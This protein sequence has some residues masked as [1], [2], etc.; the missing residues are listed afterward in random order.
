[1][2][3]PAT[4]AIWAGPSRTRSAVPLLPL[5][6]L[7]LVQGITEFLPISSSGHLILVWEGLDAGGL[8]TP[9]EAGGDRLALDVAVHVGT[10]AAVCGY[11]RRDLAA[12]I[13]G[14]LRWL[15]GGRDA[16]ARLAINVAVATLP[17][18]AVGLSAREMVAEHLRSVELVA[19][20]TLIFGVALYAA[21]RAGGL[22]RKLAEMDV[23]DALIV[24]ML[25][26]LALMPGTS[27]AGITAT[28]GRMLGYSR[29]EAARFALLLGI[30]TIAG[31]GV[32]AGIDLA[33]SDA[34]ALRLDALVAAVLACGAAWLAIALLM[35]WLRRQTF[36][37]FVVYRL[38][39]GLALLGYV[40][41]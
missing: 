28:A 12:M 25:Q 37:P 7:A 23:P 27:R 3:G 10:L 6:L 24:G 4:T 9:A 36:T 19:W 21:D 41:L 29:Q 32:L 13:R 2:T 11:F 39:L 16:D 20:T 40:Y 8:S 15:R 22:R 26:I 38:A 35:R 1:M 30:P 34:A 31:A 18:V 17:V 14:G 5:V 33:G